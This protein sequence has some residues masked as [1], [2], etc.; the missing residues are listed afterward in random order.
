[1]GVADKMWDSITTVIK[2]KALRVI[3]WVNFMIFREPG[4]LT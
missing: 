4:A 2:M 1:M 3:E